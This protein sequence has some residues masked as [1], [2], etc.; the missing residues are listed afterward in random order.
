MRNL[1]VVL[2]SLLFAGIPWAHLDIAG[3]SRSE[4]DAG[5]FR[6]GATGFG[7][8]T[9]L[10]FLGSYEPLNSPAAGAAGGKVVV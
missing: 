6:K 9:L 7:V 10:E 2:C 8:R 1:T 3:P 5:E 4:E